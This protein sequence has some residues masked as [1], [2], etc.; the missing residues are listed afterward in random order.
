MPDLSSARALFYNKDLFS[1]AGIAAPP[2]TWD[3]FEADAK[4][5][6]AL[7]D[8]NVG[9]AMP[10]GPEEAQAE[11]SIWMFNNGGDWKTDGKWTINSP[12][13][14]DD[15]DV[16]QEARRDDK[17]TQNNPGKTNRTDG[18]FAA[19]QVGQGRHGRRASRRCRPQLDK[20]KKVD[21]GD[22]ADADQG[23]QRAADLRRHR[24]PDGLQEAGQPGRGQ[25]VL[26]PLLPAGP[27]QH[28]H[29]GRGLPAGHE[30]GRAAVLV[31]PEAEGLPRHP[32]ER[33]RSRRP[34]TRPGTR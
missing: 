9:Y 16:P 26:R 28:V 23:R 3:E 17:V 12:Q 21:Y 30:A 34:T 1:K 6:T 20:D 25:G 4:K 32:A 7:G 8:G 22:R 10:L 18:A 24:L 19:V 15:A 33:A 2:K 14:V 29:Q 31:R 27:G 5:I 13:N 11:F